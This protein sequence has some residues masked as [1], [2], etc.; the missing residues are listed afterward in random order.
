MVW[1]FFYFYYFLKWTPHTLPVLS[2]MAMAAARQIFAYQPFCRLQMEFSRCL[3]RPNLSD[4]FIAFMEAFVVRLL[5][6]SC[7]FWDRNDSKHDTDAL[8]REQ[9]GK[10]VGWLAFGFSPRSS[11]SLWQFLAF[12]PG[13]VF[14]GARLRVPFWQGVTYLPLKNTG[15]DPLLFPL[16]FPLPASPCPEEKKAIIHFLFTAPHTR[17]WVMSCSPLQRAWCLV[18]VGKFAVIWPTVK[19]LNYPFANSLYSTQKLW[20]LPLATA[21]PAI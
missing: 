17:T 7:L 20:C 14:A 12:A 21:G 1:V 18:D 19:F 11:A 13:S 8:N 5:F 15:A 4:D 3:C 2:V 6:F 9:G 16:P 10:P